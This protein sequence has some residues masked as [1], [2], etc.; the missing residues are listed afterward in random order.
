MA[1][2]KHIP[3]TPK[4]CN[5]RALVAF[6]KKV[7]AEYRARGRHNLPWR[8]TR[9]P[10][11]ILVSEIMLQQTQV[12]RVIPFYKKFLKQ[13]PNM[14]ALARA[15]LSAVLRIWQGLGYGRRA[16]FLHSAAREIVEKHGGRVPSEEATLLALPGIGIYTAGALRALAFGEGSVPVETNIRT[17]LF[18]HFFPN[19]K[20]VSD[21]EL[22][23]LLKKMESRNTREWFLALMDYG[24]SLKARGVRRNTQSA[25]HTPQKPFRG[26]Q[27]EV[28]GRVLRAL[29]EKPQSKSALLRTL[30]IF[31]RECTLSVLVALQKENLISRKHRIFFLGEG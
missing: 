10:Y 5:A 27:R 3:K 29:A 24:A 11:R 21:A 23:T 2:E 31:P 9:D 28:R 6:K 15:P 20:K 7:W 12:A 4:G 16:K 19:R 25:H 1:L 8:K 30:S 26:S 14:R 18:H 17:A 13:F 22:S